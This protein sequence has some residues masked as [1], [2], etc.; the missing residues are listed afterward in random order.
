MIEDKLGQ[1]AIRCWRILEAKGKLD[2]K[3]VRSFS[4]SSSLARRTPTN[5][6]PLSPSSP[7]S[8]SSPS[9]TLAK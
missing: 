6:M 9:K 1:V 3:H 7:A 4:S 2:E 8:P 5:S